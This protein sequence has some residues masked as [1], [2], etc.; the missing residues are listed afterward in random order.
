MVKL[1]V[2][3][4]GSVPKKDLGD[5]LWLSCKL[6]RE[7]CV[8][9]LL[10]SGVSPTIESSSGETPLMV[11][12]GV[13]HAGIARLLIDAGSDVDHFTRTGSSALHMVACFGHEECAVALLGGRASTTVRD[14]DG[15]TPLIIAAKHCHRSLKVVKRLTDSM[16]SLDGQNKTRRTA[17]HYAAHKAIGAEL[18]L[19][20]G[21][22]PNIQDE[23]G[24]TPMILAAIEG[25]D[26]VVKS[27]LAYSAN[28]DIRNTFG[29]AAV[30]YLAMKNHCDAIIAIEGCHGKLDIPDMEGNVP[31]WYAVNHNR[32]DAVK[33]LLIGNC[34]PDPPWDEAG[35]PCGGIPLDTALKKGLFGIAKLLILAGCDLTPLYA[36]LVQIQARETER[37]ERLRI[38]RLIDVPDPEVLDSDP[39]EKEAMGWFQD[40]VHCPHS[41]RQICRILIRKYIG[42]GFSSKGCELPLPVS[43]RDYVTLKEVEDHHIEGTLM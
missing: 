36:W 3:V 43:L 35:R 40:W 2:A 4:P 17:L 38:S 34:N 25:F 15:N 6:G 39:L 18:L 30:H 37:Q 8:Q 12:C 9:H 13:G 27:L 22:N 28:P 41:L 10:S 42:S 7:E 14:A 23:D 20:A 26:N 31:L 24:N 1:L 11:A 19:A 21:A 33:A 29:K 16:T 5:A 32:P